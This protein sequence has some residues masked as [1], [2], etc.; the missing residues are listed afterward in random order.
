MGLYPDAGELDADSQ[1]LIDLMSLCKEVRCFEFEGH[2]YE[3]YYV[4]IVKKYH[5]LNPSKSFNVW[6]QDTQ[7]MLR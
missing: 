5:R 6:L 2:L 3:G 1:R 7:K 4:D